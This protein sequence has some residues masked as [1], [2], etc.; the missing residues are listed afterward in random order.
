MALKTFQKNH[1]GQSTFKCGDCGKTTRDTGNN[2]S[3]GLCPL[4][5]KKAELE[6]SLSDG[7]ITQAQHDEAMAKLVAK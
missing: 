7:H 1:L 2:G 6:N 4:C 5:Y 3:V